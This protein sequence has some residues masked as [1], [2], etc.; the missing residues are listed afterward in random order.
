M[1]AF[2]T[3][4]GIGEAGPDRLSVAA[5]KA[6]GAARLVIASPRFHAGLAS[7]ID[8]SASMRGWPTPFADLYA[9]IEQYRGQSVVLCAT[10]DP[11]WFGAGSSVIKHFGH[12]HCTV[13]PHLSGFQLVASRMGWALDNCETVTI[14]GR[15]L[16]ALV[17]KLYRRAKILVLADSHSSPAAVANLLDAHGFGAAHMTVLAEMGGAAEARFDGLANNWTHAVPDFHII[18]IACPDVAPA[19]TGFGC[20]DT[21]FENTGKLTKREARASAL[22]KLSPFPGA[23]FWDVGAGSGA[24]AIEFMRLAPRSQAFAIDKDKAQIA[25]ARRNAARC[26]VP[27]LTHIEADLPDGLDV[28]P[29]PDAIFIG[30]GLSAAVIAHCCAALQAGGNVVAHAVTLESEA[31]LVDAWRHYGGFLTRLAVTYADPVG[32]F[33]GWRPLMPVTQWHFGKP[34]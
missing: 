11:L 17:S 2:I 18:A 26:G 13:I 28:L 34:A 1:A 10:G 31:V 21:V 12:E 15:P 20:D 7:Y 14:H 32:G 33:N 5:Q 22:S 8:G 3:I 16:D 29:R 27:S 9:I 30:G 6:L 25:M 19:Q 24:V 23:V 4:L